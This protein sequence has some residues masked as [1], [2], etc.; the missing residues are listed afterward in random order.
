MSN[1]QARHSL[2]PAAVLWDMDGTL[3]DSDGLWLAAER[4]V[5][6]ESIAERSGAAVPELSAVAERA[7]EGASLPECARV[8]K[9]EGVTLPQEAIIERLVSTVEHELVAGGGIPWAAGAVALLMSLVEV[10]IPSVLVTGTPMRVARHVLEAVPPGSFAGAITGDSSLPAKP[11][12]DRYRAAADMAD[13]NIKDCLVFEDSGTGI[14]AGLAAGAT[15]VAVT[16]LARIPAPEDSRY[17]RIA[18][19]LGLDAAKL[20]QLRKCW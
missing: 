12:P 16:D 15:V 2:F 13:A 10:G 8:L 11:A 5:Y 14:R 7:L 1:R 18:N 3:I 9:A 19:F 17:R 6:R 20:A 4:A